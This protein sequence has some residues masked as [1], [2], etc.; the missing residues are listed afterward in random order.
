MEN[1]FKIG[2]QVRHITDGVTIFKVKAV[3]FIEVN[4]FYDISNGQMLLDKRPEQELLPIEE[5]E[6]S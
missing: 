4:Y 6:V 2:D 5:N 1:K 3:Y